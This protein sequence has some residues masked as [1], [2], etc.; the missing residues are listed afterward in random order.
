MRLPRAASGLRPVRLDLTAT[1]LNRALALEQRDPIRASRLFAEAAA[2]RH[3]MGDAKEA[4]ATGARS[5]MLMPQASKAYAAWRTYPAMFDEVKVTGLSE[6]P[7]ATQLTESFFTTYD[8]FGESP[9]RTLARQSRTPPGCV[10]DALTAEHPGG[11]T[12][13]SWDFIVSRIGSSL[14]PPRSRRR[15]QS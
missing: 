7:T 12:A 6:P 5:I 14:G 13:C 15:A 8:L 3:R 10:L 2:G 9:S 4:F 1:A 11:V